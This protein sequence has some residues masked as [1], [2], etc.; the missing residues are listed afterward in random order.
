V[1]KPR[2]SP[3]PRATITP[4]SFSVAPELLGLPL[5]SP[6]RRLWAM[7]L[8]L[9]P[10]AVLASAGPVVFMAFFTAIVIWRFLAARRRQSGIQT[11]GRRAARVAFAILAFVLVLRIGG[12]VFDRDQTNTDE[13][14]PG[15]V[16]SPEDIARLVERTAGAEAAADVREAFGATR[17][18]AAQAEQAFTVAQ[19]D[20]VVLAHAAAI[21]RGDS[22]AI[23]ETRDAATAAIA[24][25]RIRELEEDR[26]R[27]RVVNRQM[28]DR[29]D[30]LED[31]LEEAREPPGLRSV[32]LGFADDLGIGFGWSALYFTLFL[33]VGRG[34]TPGKRIAGVRVLRLDGKPMSWWYSFER[35]GG[36]FASLTTGLLGFAQILWDR[37]RQGL[38]DK[39]VETVVV[40]DN[41]RWFRTVRTPP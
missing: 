3:D 2:T 21:R 26:D 12:R 35:F 34:Q 18:S 23:G 28:A 31:E 22:V 15:A 5:A 11:A 38:H 8:D 30:T 32:L 4:E 41:R 24:G 37:N 14:A 39:I 1:K 16:V 17:D 7:L 20:S 33:A 29:I 6:G 13:A 40:R 19:R 36:Y 9:V 10:I 25:D 27:A